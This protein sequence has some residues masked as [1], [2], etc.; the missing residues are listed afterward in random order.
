MAAAIDERSEPVDRS[1]R[2]DRRLRK[3][4]ILWSIAATASLLLLAVVG[5]P[6]IA[7]ELT[8]IIPYAIE[9]KLGAAVDAQARAMLDSRHIGAAFECGNSEWEV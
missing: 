8:P 3:K 6:L 2:I 9:R 7:T 1:G 5:V 4:V